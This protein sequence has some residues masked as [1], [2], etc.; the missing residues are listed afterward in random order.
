M[1]PLGNYQN[2]R[3]ADKRGANVM[4]EAFSMTFIVLSTSLLSNTMTDSVC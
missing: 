3:N 1:I 4:K 2:N